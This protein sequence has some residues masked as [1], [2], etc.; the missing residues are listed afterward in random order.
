MSKKNRRRPNKKAERREE[1]AVAWESIVQMLFS[2]VAEDVQWDGN[3]KKVTGAIRAR[4]WQSVLTATK[5]RPPQSY[6]DWQSYY[7]ACQVEHLFKKLPIPGADQALREAAF[8]T[9]MSDEWRNKRT[10]QRFRVLHARAVEAGQFEHKNPLYGRLMRRVQRFIAAT[11][12]DSPVME[13]IYARCNFGPGSCVGVGG[14][15]TH[16]YAKLDALTC[17]D[18]ALQPFMSAVWDH[19][20][21][22]SM[23]LPGRQ[24]KYRCPT[25]RR[26]TTYDVVS[27][28][29]EHFRE[30]FSRWVKVVDYNKIDLFPKML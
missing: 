5:A 7:A 13:D 18:A 4:D 19:A 15:S 1:Q 22:R 29:P 10:N 25:T 30:E 3:V 16:P 21:F 11:L 27:E 12:G 8:R 17:T 9:L 2:R 26:L 23:F 6:A 24:I 28:D 20:Q 14:D